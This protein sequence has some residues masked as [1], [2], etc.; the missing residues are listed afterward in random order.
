MDTDITETAM[1]CE[2]RNIVDSLKSLMIEHSLPLW[3]REGCDPSRGGFVERFDIEGRAD[4]KAARRV[5]VQARQIYCFVKAAQMSWYPEGRDIATKGLEY[6]LV[7][8]KSPDGRPSWLG[9]DCQAHNP[10]NVR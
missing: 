6:L 9:C 7:R 1:R 8:A 5:L 4:C 3:S 10:N 2:S